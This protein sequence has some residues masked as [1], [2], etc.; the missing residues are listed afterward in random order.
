M[1]H[2]L[3]SRNLLMKNEKSFLKIEHFC[4]LLVFPKRFYEK[5]GVFITNPPQTFK[6]ITSNMAFNS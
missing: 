3:L 1:K 2:S 4:V 5:A 6:K